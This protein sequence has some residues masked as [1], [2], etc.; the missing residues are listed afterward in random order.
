VPDTNPSSKAQAAIGGDAPLLHFLARFEGNERK[1]V[2]LALERAYLLGGIVTCERVR[3][4]R[5][6]VPG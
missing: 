1:L 3:E 4:L 5:D 6:P 2:Y